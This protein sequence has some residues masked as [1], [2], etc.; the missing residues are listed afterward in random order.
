MEPTNQKET[1]QEAAKLTQ[2]IQIDEAKI[3]AHLGE[4]VRST[5]EDRFT[6]IDAERILNSKFK[7][8]KFNLAK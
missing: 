7:T 3:R 8:S 6:Q 5:V 2:V 4:V 1:G